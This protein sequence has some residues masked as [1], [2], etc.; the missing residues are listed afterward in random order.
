MNCFHRDTEQGPVTLTE[1]SNKS[2]YH[3]LKTVLEIREQM[4]MQMSE[5][6]Y[7]SPDRCSISLTVLT[8]GYSY[9]TANAVLIK[10]KNVTI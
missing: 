10:W 1:W 3:K 2:F 9:Y 6:N 4:L 5:N 7:F 8:T